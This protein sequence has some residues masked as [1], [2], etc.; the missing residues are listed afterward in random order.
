MV[1]LCSAVGRR[2]QRRWLGRNYQSVVT[3]HLWLINVRIKNI[4]SSSGIGPELAAVN[5]DWGE[6]LKICIILYLYLSCISLFLLGSV[7]NLLA[8]A[9]TRLST[10][11][12]IL[13]ITRLR[14]W[15]WPVGGLYSTSHSL[16][17]IQ[18]L[19]LVTVIM[20]WCLTDPKLWHP[21]IPTMLKTITST[22]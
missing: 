19:G 3:T 2:L 18:W 10:S 9:I 1:M 4:A 16:R 17:L 7:S 14:L 11:Y 22:S 6:Q 8:L 15:P 20:I 21:R 12:S 5:R 13:T